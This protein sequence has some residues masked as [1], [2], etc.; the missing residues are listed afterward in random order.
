MQYLRKSNQNNRQNLVISA[1]LLIL[2][3]AICVFVFVR[4]SGVQ[5]EPTQIAEEQQNSGIYEITKL[6]ERTEYENPVSVD[7]STVDEVRIR[8]AG[9]YILSGKTEQTVIIDAQEQ[10]VHLILNG[11]DIR[12]DKGPAIQVESAG[13]VIITLADG[14]EN[15]V[16]DSGNYSKEEECNA[17]I[18]STADITING[19]GSLFV[20]GYY[21]DAIHTKDL[22]K[23][24]D[25]SVYVQAKR[26]GLRG[27]DGMVIR[28]HI[29][30]VESEGTGLQTTNSN[31]AD[32]GVIEICGGDIFITAGKYGMAAV[33][34]VYVR[35]CTI[36]CLSVMTEIKAEGEQYVEEGCFSYE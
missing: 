6:D 30:T 8:E 13:K 11:V 3:L 27:N 26:N 22:L 5:D 28:P 23:I 21:K 9:D 17:A 1:V 15:V 36:S 10:I 24:I 34:D 18:Y 31:Q 35:E 20:Y 7:L 33:S 14:T 29:L 25:G 16:R 4:E 2:G 32:K 19:G 12:S